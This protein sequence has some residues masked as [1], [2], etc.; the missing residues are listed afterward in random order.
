MCK[1]AIWGGL[2]V[3]CMSGQ[4]P[5]K[6][7]HVVP[8][9]PCVVNEV[10]MHKEKAERKGAAKRSMESSDETGMKSAAKRAIEAEK[11]RPR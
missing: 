8:A 4:S 1:L 2:A 7:V 10:Q 9:Q 5:R 6:E 11:E 3:I